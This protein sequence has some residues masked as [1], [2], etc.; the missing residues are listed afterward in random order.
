MKKKKIK[1]FFVKLKKVLGIR[2]I[3]LLIIL[4]SFNTYAWFI[5]TSKVETGLGAKVKSW[6]IKFKNEDDTIAENVTFN[7]DDL[8]PGMN[9]FNQQVKIANDG[10]TN[11]IVTFMLTSVRILDTV[12]NVSSSMIS[13]QLIEK[14]Q[15]EYPFEISLGLDKD[16]VVPNSNAIFSVD[17]MW[18]FETNDD[19]LDTYWG[20][21]AYAY[22]HSHPGDASI[23]ID[24]TIKIDQEEENNG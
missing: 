18:D 5:F 21:Q 19:E 16:I 12:Y 11:A 13:D 4:L 7:I 3:L 24:L 22:N 15:S 10:D 23:Q 14:L 8:Y 9:N 1:D 20:E 17:V 2:T 6:N